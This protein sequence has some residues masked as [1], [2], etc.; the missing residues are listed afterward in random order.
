MTP[1]DL[2]EL[3]NREPPVPQPP[4][5]RMLDVHQSLISRWCRGERAIPQSRA[6][7]IRQAIRKLRAA[8][9]LA[10]TVEQRLI[11]GLRRLTSA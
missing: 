9:I 2:L 10:E 11:R 8:R 1:N 5:A 3:L 6:K 4:L 7:E